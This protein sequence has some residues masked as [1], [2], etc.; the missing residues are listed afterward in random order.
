VFQFL[1]FLSATTLRLFS[2][3][4]YPDSYAVSTGENSGV[5]RAQRETYHALP[6]SAAAY[7]VWSFTSKSFMAQAKE[8]FY[9]FPRGS[10]V[11]ERPWPFLELFRHMVGLLG[12]AISPSQ[13]L[14]LHRTPQHRKTWTNIHAL[15]GIQTHDPRNQP[16]KTHA[17]DRTATV[18]GILCFTSH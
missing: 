13:S 12:R 3:W 14:Y 7:D 5:K 4:T 8:L 15:S 16:V 9:V 18:T 10:T 1:I 2:S 6:S 11:L 17:S